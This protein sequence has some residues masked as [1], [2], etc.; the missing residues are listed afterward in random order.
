MKKHS[1]ENPTIKR[2]LS[3]DIET[4]VLK[5]EIDFG[6]FDKEELEALMAALLLLANK[7]K[8]IDSG[9]LKIKIDPTTKIETATVYRD[10]D[11]KPVFMTED[12]LEI[13][14]LQDP[15][16]SLEVFVTQLKERQATNKVIQ[17]IQTGS[18]GTEP[19]KIN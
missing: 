7:D 17:D 12:P 16:K 4:K 15:K 3:F 10:S 8:N 2:D 6:K 19:K 1:K 9:N 5:E 14:Y 13:M 11:H 18:V